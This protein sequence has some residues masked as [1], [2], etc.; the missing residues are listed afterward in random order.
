[1]PVDDDGQPIRL[2]EYPYIDCRENIYHAYK[3]VGWYR[4][5]HP[6]T[7]QRLTVKEKVCRDCGGIRLEFYDKNRQR[8]RTPV[9][10]PAPGY[11]FHYTEGEEKISRDEYQRVLLK[12]ATVFDSR[13]DMHDALRPNGNGRRRRG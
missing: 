6:Q 3:I 13:D 5:T 10:E 8:V 7:R 9:Y 2:D 12:D 4:M 11:R 1:M